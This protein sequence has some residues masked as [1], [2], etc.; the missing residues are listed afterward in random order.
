MKLKDKKSQALPRYA[1]PDKY[2]LL[3]IEWN[4]K[5]PS[6]PEKI[7]FLDYVYGN[8]GMSSWDK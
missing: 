5:N 1:Y 7:K 4:I 6:H 2:T 8:D 3:E